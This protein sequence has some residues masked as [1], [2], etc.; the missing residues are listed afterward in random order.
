MDRTTAGSDCARGL[1][2]A[3]VGATGRFPLCKTKEDLWALLIEGRSAISNRTLAL[4]APISVGAQKAAGGNDKSFK[5]GFIDDVDCFDAEFFRISPKEACLMDPQ[6]R[7]LLQ[8]CWHALE[9]ARIKPSRLAGSDVGVFVGTCNADYTEL[10]I[11]QGQAAMAH[12]TTGTDASILSNRVSFIFDFRGPSLTV[13]TACSS[14]LV[15]LHLAA[16]SIQSGECSVALAAGVNVCRSTRRFEAFARAG[17]LAQDGLCKTFDTR[18]D[19]YVR[20]E[21]VCALV[22]KELNSAERDGNPIY[23]VIRA[24]AI[25]HGGRTRGLT[26]TSPGQQARLLVDTYQK[27][28]VH[29]ASVGYIEVHGT[30]TSLGDPIECLGLKSA[31]E[32][33][34]QYADGDDIRTGYCGLGTVKTCI[35][36][37]EAA[38]GIAGVIKVLLAIKHKT[39]PPQTNLLQLNP[40]IN[41]DNSPFYIATK[42]TAWT[43]QDVHGQ[44]VARRAGVSSFGFGGA[45]AHVVIDECELR[46][47]PSRRQILRDEL[48]VLSAGN[49]ERL[50]ETAL[51]LSSFLLKTGSSSNVSL[52]DLAYSLQ[53][54]REELPARAAFVVSNPSTLHKRLLEFAGRGLEASGCICGVVQRSKDIGEIFGD[55]ETA[56]NR[57]ALSELATLWIQGTNIDWK[58]LYIGEP[59]ALT[60]LPLYPF[61]REK[62]WIDDLEIPRKPVETVPLMTASGTFAL[63]PLLQ[64]NTSDL[65]E[66]RFTSTFSGEEFFLSQHVVNG[67]S[68]LPGVCYLEMARAAL[69]ASL[70]QDESDFKAFELKNVVWSRPLIVGDARDVHIGL[71]ADESNEIA[72][73][74][75]T[76]ESAQ[77]NSKERMVHAHGRAVLAQGFPHE[78]PDRIDLSALRAT[79]DRSIDVALCYERFFETGIEYGPAYRGLATVQGAVTAG[80]WR[81]ILAQIKLPKCVSET[82]NEFALHPSVVDSAL[83]ASVGVALIDADRPEKLRQGRS[84]N[85]SLPFALE[86]LI[87]IDRTPE[88]VWVYVRPCVSPI[89]GCPLGI[90][91]SRKLDIDVADE[92]GRVILKLRGFT[93]RS[94]EGERPSEM[95]SS[96]RTERKGF[97][98]EKNAESLLNGAVLLAP[99]WDAT[100]PQLVVRW[101]PSESAVLMFGGTRIQQEMWKE[102]YPQLKVLLTE[103]ET[104]VT[105]IV[106]RIGS[107]GHFDHVVWVAPI[108]TTESVTDELLIRGQAIGVISLYR[109][110]KALLLL[111]YG[112]SALGWSI[113][114]RQ[115]QAIGCTEKCSPTHASVHGFI[116]SIAKEYPE[117]RIRLIDVDGEGEWLDELL[118]LPPDPQGNAWAYRTGEWYQ[119][120]LLPSEMISPQITLYRRGGV[121][122]LI[123]GAG[124][125]GEAFTEYLIQNYQARVIWVGR[126]ELDP[127]I[128]AKI[129]RLSLLGP[130]PTYLC[131]DATDRDALARAHEAIKTKYGGIH[132][133]VHGAIVLSDKSIALMDEMQFKASLMAKVDVSVRLAQVFAEDSLDFVLF[134]SSLQSFSKTAG[135][136]N[137]AAGCTF[138]DAFAHRLAQ[139]WPCPIKV[140]NWGYWGS[141]GIVATEAYRDRMIQRGIGS[142]ESPEGMNALECLLSS[143]TQQSAF[144]KVNDARI[145]AMRFSGDAM[146]FSREPVPSVIALLRADS[147][148]CQSYP[149]KFA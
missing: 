50:R 143:A 101:P 99:R 65:V 102:R 3:I 144:V 88:V 100:L 111:G 147:N 108:D 13:D 93:S 109:L 1:E 82:R 115:T 90:G 62:Y 103:A 54:S 11:A 60:A 83:Q 75:Y 92:A 46:E 119:Q 124:G 76:G 59:V 23:G 53:M 110:T 148:D 16:R 132:G 118:R 43:Q 80:E 112:S 136:A 73:E 8:E 47:E 2:V 123:G 22:L 30:G 63:H 114:T 68:V 45:Y 44:P 121:Y 56:V 86:R 39:I 122:V 117:W 89:A 79:C 12:S 134:F 51:E 35:G 91:N 19:G 15:A 70:S 10:L 97:E 37:L 138:K 31:F 78:E 14:S 7:I 149:S 28:G 137:Y 5:A 18:A 69:A 84:G 85:P 66:Q 6:Q 29:P 27:A 26:V 107:W 42:S 113:V 94:F 96:D 95:L 4:R 33:L 98:E 64:R 25:N 128:Q 34:W 145:M 130:A 57:R 61:A 49:M 41:L 87:I 55:A 141:V 24:I 71:Y 52:A 127:D 74:V 105:T 32:K 129:D 58:Q 48:I 126:R 67:R 38:A 135:Q 20:G 17:M 104:S 116:G 131:A 142:I 146:I 40:L 21:G 125:I 9:D 36:H 139:V 133:L 120:Q 81:F 140:M 72:F 77:R 106:D